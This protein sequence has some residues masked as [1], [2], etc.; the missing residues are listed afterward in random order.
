MVAAARALLFGA[1]GH[2]SRAQDTEQVLHW[3]CHVKDL[4]RSGNEWQ[5]RGG[6]GSTVKD[7]FT[8]I[9]L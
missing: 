3:H 5:S 6:V 1:K 7:S 2:L 9:F 8:G 4:S